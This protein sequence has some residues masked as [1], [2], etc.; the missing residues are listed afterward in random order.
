MISF[1]TVK[2]REVTSASQDASPGIPTGKWLRRD[3]KKD[4][5]KWANSIMKYYQNRNPNKAAYLTWD[6][7]NSRLHWSTSW[8]VLASL[9]NCI[10]KRPGGQPG[11]NK[12]SPVC[13]FTTES[14][15]SHGPDHCNRQHVFVLNCSTNVM[16]VQAVVIHAVDRKQ[17]NLQPL[18]PTTARHYYCKPDALTY[19]HM[20]H[21]CKQVHNE[22]V[23]VTFL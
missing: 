23:G 7:G 15:K 17:A 4:H 2:R 1:I 22:G 8:R 9:D 13:T 21:E 10:I 5:K 3:S 11:H 16:G 6:N 19:G 20:T 12:T 14:V 18:P